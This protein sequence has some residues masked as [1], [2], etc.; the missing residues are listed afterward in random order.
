MGIYRLSQC[1]AEDFESIYLYGVTEFGL[2]Q[3]ERY[4]AGLQV[5]FEQ[6]AD[7]PYLY[8]AVD[9]IR[10]GYRLSVYCSHA[11]YYCFEGNKVLIVRILRNQDI[12]RAL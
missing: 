7:Q 6:L 8:P 4:V 10:L 11:I 12:T 3:A 2:K 1:A 5:R 9:H